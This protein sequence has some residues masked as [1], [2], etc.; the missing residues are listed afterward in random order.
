[1]IPPTHASPPMMTQ[2]EE[3]KE[4]VIKSEQH[5]LLFIWV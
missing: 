2:R 4:D 1:M 5:E 3:M